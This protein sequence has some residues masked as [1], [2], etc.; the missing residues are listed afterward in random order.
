MF[1]ASRSTL[2]RSRGM[3]IELIIGTKTVVTGA[4]EYPVDRGIEPDVEGHRGRVYLILL[5]PADSCRTLI[6]LARDSA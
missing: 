4:S 2:T 1:E 6:Q 3:F 5:S